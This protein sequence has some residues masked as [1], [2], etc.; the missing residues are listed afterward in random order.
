MKKKT[1]AVVASLTM[2]SLLLSR[3][4]KDRMYYIFKNKRTGELNVK[5]SVWKGQKLVWTS[6]EPDVP[7]FWIR[8]VDNDFAENKALRLTN[9]FPGSIG[10]PA[11]CTVLKSV[12]GDYPYSILPEDPKKVKPYD[13][14]QIFVKNCR[15][16]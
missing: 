5:N 13:P 3:R 16:C 9:D 8:F 1:V 6:T 7:E 11:Q 14:P 10:S 15:F 2:I 12:E 4:R